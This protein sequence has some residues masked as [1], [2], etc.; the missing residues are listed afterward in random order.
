MFWGV[1]IG[2]AGGATYEWGYSLLPSTFLYREHFLGWAPASIP[3]DIAGNPGDQDNDGVF[4]TVA[5]D[6][7]R[8]FVDFNNDGTADLIDANL[9]GTPE[10]AFVTL[11][12][13]Q[14]QF[15][16]D[17]ANAAGGGDL[18]EAHFWATGDFTMAYGENADTAHDV[19]PVARPRLHRHPRHRLHLARP[20]GEEV[21]EPRRSSPPR[22]GRRRRSRSESTPRSTRSTA[23]RSPTRFRRAGSTCAGTTSITLPDQTTI[24]TAPTISGAGTVASPY[25]LTWPS[26]TL[27]NMAENQEIVVRFTARDDGGARRGNPQPESGAGGRH[28]DGGRLRADV[29]GDGLRLRRYR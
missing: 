28:A 26:A 1:G 12:R 7:T 17:P 10:S 11:N 15:F 21:G 19:D 14:T 18:S 23:W 5:Q 13:L 27:G 6:N 16:Y 29:H 8:V 24:T 4:L 2:N 3:I 9:D 20:D 25:V 22:P